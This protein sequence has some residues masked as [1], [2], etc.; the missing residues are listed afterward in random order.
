MDCSG[1]LNSVFF[2][3]LVNYAIINDEN[4]NVLCFL[5]NGSLGLHC[6]E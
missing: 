3:C 1:K 2:F 5:C 4:Q 6:T